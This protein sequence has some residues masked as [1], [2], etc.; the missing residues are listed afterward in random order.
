M[1][2]SQIST[3]CFLPTI[4][5]DFQHAIAA[6]FYTAD[7]LNVSFGTILRGDSELNICLLVVCMKPNKLIKFNVPRTK[8]LFVDKL[9]LF[10]FS[11][12]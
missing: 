5:C 11:T 4:I 12:I 6:F 10:Q 7:K 8:F 9:P 1:C 3:A 2:V